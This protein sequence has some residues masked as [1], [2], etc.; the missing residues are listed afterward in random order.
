[1][2]LLKTKKN[3]FGGQ[4]FFNKVHGKQK[5]GDKCMQQKYDR[6]N[7]YFKEKKFSILKY[8]LLPTSDNFLNYIRIKYVKNIIIHR[9]IWKKLKL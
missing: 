9:Q 2:G 7:F 8:I 5:K 3:L 4:Y 6:R 1:M